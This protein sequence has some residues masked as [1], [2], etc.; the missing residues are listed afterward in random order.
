MTLRLCHL[1]PLSCPCPATMDAL[2]MAALDKCMA[3]KTV[4]ERLAA[5]KVMHLRYHEVRRHWRLVVLRKASL[6]AEI[7]LIPRIRRCR[8]AAT[9]RRNGSS[10]AASGTSST[11]AATAMVPRR[12]AAAQS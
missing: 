7:L 2:A 9:D 12:S 5:A 11:A 6:S 10:V 3:A 8:V 1:P 4:E